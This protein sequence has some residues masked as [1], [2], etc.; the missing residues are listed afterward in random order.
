MV[1]LVYDNY[2]FFININIANLRK[3]I[4]L[5]KF[6]PVRNKIK[7]LFHGTYLGKIVNML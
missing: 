6:Y 1:T 5:I 7:Y 2:V 3:L 4:I